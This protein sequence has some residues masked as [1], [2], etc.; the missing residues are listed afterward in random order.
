MERCVLSSARSRATG[1]FMTKISVITLTTALALGLYG[2]F[3]VAQNAG[4]GAGQTGTPQTSAP[5]TAGNGHSDANNDPAHHHTGDPTT[6]PIKQRA[7]EQKDAA[8]R[9]HQG[10]RL[11]DR[12]RPAELTPTT[13]TNLHLSNRWGPV[14]ECSLSTLIWLSHPAVS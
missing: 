2:P 6:Q 9:D 5:G 8:T 11:P 4:A 7:A 3:L 10:R 12:R 13:A 1:E 14:G